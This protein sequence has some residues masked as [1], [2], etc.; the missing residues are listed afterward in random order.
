MNN[1]NA[2]IKKYDDD[3]F[4][5]IINYKFPST[6]VLHEYHHDVFHF[7][8]AKI[9]IIYVQYYHSTDDHH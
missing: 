6:T 5:I 7:T 8:K 4:Y 1:N 2:T 3:K 9:H